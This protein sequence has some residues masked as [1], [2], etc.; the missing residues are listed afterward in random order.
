M[1]LE[2]W[3]HGTSFMFSYYLAKFWPILLAA[4]SMTFVGY[5][6]GFEEITN[7]LLFVFTIEAAIFAFFWCVALQFA[8]LFSCN[9]ES[10]SYQ[11]MQKLAN[12]LLSVCISLLN[13]ISEENEESDIISEKD[14]ISSNSDSDIQEESLEPQECNREPEPPSVEQKN[15]RSEIIEDNC[16]ES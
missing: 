10:Y 13:E 7:K 9:K 16:S 4:G 5:T 2:L 3:L 14:E 15:T 12:I 8:R 11:E 1:F 6:T